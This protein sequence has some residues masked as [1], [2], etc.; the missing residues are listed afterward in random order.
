MHAITITCIRRTSACWPISASIRIASPS[1]GAGLSLRKVSSRTR[2][3]PLQAHAGHLSR[4]NLNTML[5]LLSLS[6]SAL[7]AGERWMAAGEGGRLVC[8]LLRKY[9]AHGGDDWLRVHDE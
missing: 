9:E 1:M 2:T 7:V 5:T 6:L 3:G 8:A 4:D